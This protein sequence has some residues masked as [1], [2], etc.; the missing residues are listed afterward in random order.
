MDQF[1]KQS[2]QKQ[3]PFSDV[4]QKQAHASATPGKKS[5]LTRY[6]VVFV[7][8]LV[9][10]GAVFGVW[11]SNNKKSTTLVGVD[12]DRYQALFLTN[13]QVYFGKLSQADDKTVKINDIYYLHITQQVQPESEQQTEAEPPQLIK[14]GEELHKPDDEMFIDRSQVSFWEN[15]KDDGKVAEA[16]RE[17][18]KK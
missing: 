8:V 15:I 9:V 17:Y 6:L 16:I 12:P 3:A 10:A 18:S 7:V 13:G 2:T 14:L 5:R 11:Y 1:K 4:A